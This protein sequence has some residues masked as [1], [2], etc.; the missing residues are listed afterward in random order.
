M[1]ENEEKAG[2]FCW[3]TTTIPLIFEEE[4]RLE[5]ISHVAVD[6]SQTNKVIVTK[7]ENEVGIDAENNTI[8]VSLS[9]EETGLFKGG[10][11]EK[12]KKAFVQVNLYY[13]GGRRDATFEEEIEVYKNS[14]NKVMPD[15]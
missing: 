14:H 7:T 2:F 8:N 5:N 3:E 4:G 9:Q 12:P 10:S 6:F 15:E 11:E 13:N 1:T